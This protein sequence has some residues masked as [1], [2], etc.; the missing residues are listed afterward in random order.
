MD[1]ADL[2]AW[3]DRLAE[4]AMRDMPPQFFTSYR[5][6]PLLDRLSILL[7]LAAITRNH[8]AEEAC[9]KALT[10]LANL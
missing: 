5:A 7:A 1:V 4:K 10:I 2:G 8:R 3:A 6:R 9:R